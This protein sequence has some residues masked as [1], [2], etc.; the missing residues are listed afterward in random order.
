M[1]QK[2]FLLDFEV[3]GIQ[4][5][6]IQTRQGEIDVEIF[7]PLEELMDPDEFELG[8]LESLIVRDSV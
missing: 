2:E 4:Y 3:E 1:R 5:F 7:A 6:I 8:Y